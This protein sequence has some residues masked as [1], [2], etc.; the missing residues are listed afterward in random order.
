MT[1]VFACI[2][3]I[4]LVSVGSVRSAT[5]TPIYSSPPSGPVASIIDTSG[6]SQTKS[7]DLTVS[8]L[9][10]ISQAGNPNLNLFGSMCWNSECKASWADAQGLDPSES[11]VAIQTNLTQ[12][13]WVNINGFDASANPTSSLGALNLV[14][15]KP[16]TNDPSGSTI[17][18]LGQTML[19][20]SLTYGMYAAAG[21][22]S[23]N[24]VALYG[25]ASAGLAA[26][27]VGNVAVADGSDLV[28]G[29]TGHG[30][31]D[32]VSE[33]CL[34]NGCHSEWQLTG[35]AF[36]NDTGAA[37]EPIQQGGTAPSVAAGAS[38]ST[39]PFQVQYKYSRLTAIERVIGAMTST[40]TV[41]Q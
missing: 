25:K 29:G 32:G 40:S 9:Q 39:A 24:S 34:N 6:S 4:C 17:A 5:W 15:V 36:W 35:D 21:A 20:P 23:P 16:E 1:A 37:Y 33:I 12:I 30:S 26:Q 2:G 22:D 28:V 19:N 18:V 31:Q 38:D 8:G 10:I 13:G 41:I 27:F 11:Y 3:L 7:G 14:A